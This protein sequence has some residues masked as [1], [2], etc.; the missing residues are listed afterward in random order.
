M[1]TNLLNIV[2]R[3]VTEQGEG[4]LADA[5]RLFPYFSDYAK[6][7]HKEERV[8]F[9]RCIEMGAYQELKRTRT[10]DERQ[11]VKAT[12]ATQMN[13]KTGVARPRCVDA[14]DLLEA[15]IFK[16][17]QQPQYSSQPQY[18][19]Q[20]YSQQPQYLQQP[21]YPQQVYSQQPQA[22]M[23]LNVNVNTSVYPQVS[24][25]KSSSLGPAALI[26]GILGLC[27]GAIPVVQYFTFI[28]SI[29]AIVFGSS[30]KKKAKQTG[31]PTGMATAGVVLG[32][33]AVILTVIVVVLTGAFYYMLFSDSL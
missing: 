22:N 33:I 12:L 9:G 23:P 19:P 8:A 5:K 26:C 11:R 32:I 3:I 29:L 7:E 18:P 20:A 17:V 31:Q 10:L 21:Q 1:N 14:L 24:V 4:I 25:Q 6:N 2:N 27:G 30:A 15:V 16:P 28:L 13:A